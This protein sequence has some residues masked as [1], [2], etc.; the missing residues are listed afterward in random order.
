M[1]GYTAGKHCMTDDQKKIYDVDGNGE[2][3]LKDILYAAKVVN[4]TV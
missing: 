2:I 1:S 4:G 3:T